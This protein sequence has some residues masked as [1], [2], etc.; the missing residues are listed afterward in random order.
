MIRCD[1]QR[2]LDILI[3]GCALIILSP[4][5][6]IIS[7][8]LKFTGEGEIFYSQERVGRDDKIFLLLKF[9]TML[10][11]SPNI[12]TGT[13]TVKDDFRVL[14]FGRF[15]RSTKINELPQ[16]LNVLVGHMSIIGPRPLTRETFASY[17][18]EI[19]SSIR[20]VQPGLSG[21]GS[22]IFHDEE[23]FFTNPKNTKEIY[24]KEISPFKGELEIWYA[25][26]RTIYT[27]FTL[28]GLTIWVIFTRN[29]GLCWQL[30][31]DLPQPNSYLKSR[32]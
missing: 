24:E 30:F 16:L 13:I 2:A 19:Q 32:I 18:D 22:I 20:T 25:N 5:L 4:I 23:K 21:I 12:G 26:N 28:I 3:S 29:T 11:N 1:L 9:A 7:V 6:I 27:Y 15:L 8:I 10:K 31:C 14:P 17:S